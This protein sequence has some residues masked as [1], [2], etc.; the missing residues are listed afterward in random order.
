[1]NFTLFYDEYKLS[2]VQNTLLERSIETVRRGV[3]SSGAKEPNIQQQGRNYILLQM[4]GVDDPGEIRNI[5]GKTAKLTFH[6]VSEEGNMLLNQGKALP[7]N[8]KLIAYQ[9]D[10]RKDYKIAIQKKSLLSGDMLTNANMALSEGE[11]IV[12]FSFNKL[13]SKIF[14][15]I[16]KNNIGKQLA[17][18]LDNKLLSAATIQSAIMAGSG[19][20]TGGFTIDSA[21]ELALLLRAGALPAPLKIVEERVIGPNLG[22]D[23]IEAGKQAG[24]I[25]FLLVAIFMI[26]A[27]GLFGV[28]AC[29]ALMVNIIIIIAALSL[30]SATLT[31]PGIAGIILTIG[32]AV[33][34]NVL[35]YERIKEEFRS[36][37]FS[38][39][40]FIIR[41]GF[42]SA[43]ATIL[44]SNITTLVA[45]ILLY[46]FGVGSIK[47]FAVTLSIGIF[48]SMFTAITVTRMLIDG[49]VV[50]AKPK[51]IFAFTDVKKRT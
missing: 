49:W 15:E 33:D 9:S 25:A 36:S 44:D 37:G 39:I 34:A 29:I 21:N 3:R 12:E 35:I 46:I 41:R 24:I 17:I 14:G 47:G 5:L 18:V 32:M 38:S 2:E 50:L 42:S 19:R 22:A 10:E 13:G 4:P 27:Y 51:K 48:A 40:P 43:F 1:G 16:T 11:A 28:F 7:V 45:A 26:L 8:A 31:L 6:L 30:L 20:I 23:S